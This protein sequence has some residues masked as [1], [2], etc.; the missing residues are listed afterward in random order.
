M[1]LL[2]TATLTAAAT[3]A[4]AGAAFAEGCNWGYTAS[5]S[6]PIVAEAEIPASPVPAPATVAETTTS[7]TMSVES[8]ETAQ[9]PTDVVSQ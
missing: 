9:A 7:D 8:L 1:K 6:T 5:K 3:L 2:S 4:F